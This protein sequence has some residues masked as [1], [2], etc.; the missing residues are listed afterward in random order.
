[1]S[2]SFKTHLPESPLQS[3]DMSASESGPQKVMPAPVSVGGSGGVM[4]MPASTE[5]S[6]SITRLRQGEEVSEPSESTVVA[7]QVQPKLQQHYHQHQH[8][9]LDKVLSEPICFESSGQASKTSSSST[10]P[11]SISAFLAPNRN[12]PLFNPQQT[13][14]DNLTRMGVLEDPRKIPALPSKKSQMAAHSVAAP[15]GSGHHQLQQDLLAELI[16]PPLLAYNKII[17]QQQPQ[18][19]STNNMAVLPGI[20]VE[21]FYNGSNNIAALQRVGAAVNDSKSQFVGCGDVSTT[22]S[23]VTPYTGHSATVA[24]NEDE[25]AIYE[26][27]EFVQSHS[28]ANVNVTS[29]S[30][31]LMHKRGFC[32][33]PP[34]PLCKTV[35]DLAAPIGTK[36]TSTNGNLIQNHSLSEMICQRAS[37]PKLPKRSKT[38]NYGVNPRIYLALQSE[39][40]PSNPHRQPDRPYHNL[41]QH[42]PQLMGVVGAQPSPDNIYRDSSSPSSSCLE[43]A[44]VSKIYNNTGFIQDWDR[45]R[46]ELV[47]PPDLPVKGGNMGGEEIGVGIHSGELGV[48]GGDI[49]ERLDSDRL[50]PVC[51]RDFGQVSIEDFQSHVLECFDTDSG[52]ETMVAASEGI[53]PQR[54][55]PMC[56]TSFGDYMSQEDYENHVHSHFG[57]EMPGENFE[58]LRT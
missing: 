30:P 50:C 42:Q 10:L 48:G 5:L 49:E 24:P 45:S 18:I 26:N 14:A 54:V 32:A 17:Q 43:S 12:L 39:Q 38:E 34:P 19:L 51:S 22:L 6:S 11:S 9:Q 28:N 47:S 57:E 37:V 20:S 2:F 55:C 16:H 41:H 46:H 56:N 52:P 13:G 40:A 33:P 27:T 3:V 15:H 21:S 4:N 31:I 44:S 23:T 29:T 1:M 25:E 8:R 35:G 58:V 36:S 53:R 7:G